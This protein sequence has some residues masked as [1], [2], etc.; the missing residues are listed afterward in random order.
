[1]KN[2]E[3]EMRRYGISCKDIAEHIVCSE[4]TARN[5]ISGKSEFT[6]PEALKIRND[7]FPSMRMEYLFAA[8][9]ELDRQAG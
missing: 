4:K 3:A 5:K 8:G 7:F 6:F 9:D 1:M 2:L